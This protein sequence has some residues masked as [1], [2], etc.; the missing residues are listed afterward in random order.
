MIPKKVYF[1]IFC[2]SLFICFFIS[3]ESNSKKD[4]AYLK[5]LNTAEKY[6]GK[7]AYDSAFYHFEKL[8]TFFVEYKNS[9]TE[10][11]IHT[12]LTATKKMTT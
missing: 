8:K 5:H 7:A 11:E 3:C 4:L 6:Y 12:I 9:E 1:P 10:K 2:F